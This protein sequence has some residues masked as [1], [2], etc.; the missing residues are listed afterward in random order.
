MSTSAPKWRP[1]LVVMKPKCWSRTS[2]R[3]YG[4]CMWE[5]PALASLSEMLDTQNQK[6]LTVLSTELECVHVIN[7]VFVL[8]NKLVIYHTFS[9]KTWQSI[10]NTIPCV[11]RV[12]VC[13][14]FLEQAEDSSWWKFKNIRVQVTDTNTDLQQAFFMSEQSRDKERRGETSDL[15]RWVCRL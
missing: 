12:S 7:E 6:G 15:L 9:P 2:R 8:W 4:S 10:T 11:Q 3:R 13:I 1:S 14:G 5:A